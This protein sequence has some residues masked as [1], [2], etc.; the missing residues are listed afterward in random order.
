MTSLTTWLALLPMAIGLGGGEAN[1]PLARAIIGGSAGRDRVVAV[2][3]SLFVFG[4]QAAG[5]CERRES[6]CRGRVARWPKT[7]TRNPRL[8]IILQQHCEKLGGRG[9]SCDLREPIGE[10]VS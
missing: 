2:G 9:A 7:G 10:K 4:I 3:G 1:I 6:G 8:E 5:R